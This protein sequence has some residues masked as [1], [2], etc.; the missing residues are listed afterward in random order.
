MIKK[1]NDSDQ[2]SRL[3]LRG[4]K[5]IA[6]CELELEI[7]RVLRQPAVEGCS[8]I[9]LRRIEDFEELRIACWRFRIQT[10][11][12]QTAERVLRFAQFAA[13][14]GLRR[15]EDHHTA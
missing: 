5:S 7:T 1:V 12:Q 8:Q 10:S 6:D 11:C 3:V 13:W 15:H 4:Y 2:I 9:V 14:S